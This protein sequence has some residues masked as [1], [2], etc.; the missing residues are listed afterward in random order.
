LRVLEDI[1]LSDCV[2][3]FRNKAIDSKL[4]EIL[5]NH[6]IFSLPYQMQWWIHYFLLQQKWLFKEDTTYIELYDTNSRGFKTKELIKKL[7]GI[8]GATSPNSGTNGNSQT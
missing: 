8:E 2:L 4:S 3:F 1:E 6:A 7:R 5:N